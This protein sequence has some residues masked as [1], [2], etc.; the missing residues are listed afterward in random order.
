MRMKKFK[1]YLCSL[2]IIAT[3]FS[4]EEKFKEPDVVEFEKQS[5][6][7]DYN[8]KIISLNATAQNLIAKSG[9][10]VFIYVWSV[11]DE[12]I[13]ENLNGLNHFYEKYKTKIDF[14]FVTKDKQKDVREFLSKNN[15]NFPVL[16]SLWR[17]PKP[18]TLDVTKRGYLMSKTKRIVVDAQG[19]L[20][21]N[22]EK[23]FT[24]ADGLTKQ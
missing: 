5:V 12:N 9:R 4:C 8:W 22:S 24:T 13:V 10:V 7:A 2:L 6:V 14:V 21:W 17:I 15:Y 19:D 23:I 3:L 1:I 18:L 20:N 16:F 11:N